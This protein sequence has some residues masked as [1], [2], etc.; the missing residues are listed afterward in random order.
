MKQVIFDSNQDLTYIPEEEENSN[1][2]D[3]D[4]TGS[5]SGKYAALNHVCCK[6]VKIVT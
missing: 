5:I 2:D 1:A 4:D 6:L 3:D